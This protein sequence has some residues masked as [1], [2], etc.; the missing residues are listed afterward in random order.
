[1]KLYNVNLSNFATK[2]RLVIYE[3]GINV[4]LVPMGAPAGKKV[5]GLYLTR[6]D[7]LMY[8]AGVVS[9]LIGIGVGLGLVE[10]VRL[11]RK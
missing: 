5:F 3:K 8:G 7:F 6:R 1:M 9:V 4:E 2:S 11:F 10:L